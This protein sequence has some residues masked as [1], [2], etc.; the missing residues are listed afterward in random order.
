GDSFTLAGST[1][2]YQITN[3]TTAAGN[4]FA[5]VQIA[6][7]LLSSA[8]DGAAVLLRFAN[9]YEAAAL[10]LESI[11]RRWARYPDETIDGRTIHWSQRASFV[12]AQATALRKQAGHAG[13]GFLPLVRC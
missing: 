10:C 11:A 5:G 8:A 6:P 4:A 2:R 7:G 12:A 9:V 13:S 1:Q 3:A